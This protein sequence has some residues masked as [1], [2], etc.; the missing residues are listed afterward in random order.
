M[1]RNKF[2]TTFGEMMSE[3]GV[4]KIAPTP[5]PKPTAKRRSGGKAAPIP[6]D[7]RQEPEHRREM[8]QML[9]NIQ[10]L[11]RQRDALR[12]Q[13]AERD[14]MLDQLNT[15]I[16]EMKLKMRRVEET[17]K[18]DGERMTQLRRMVTSLKDQNQHL[19]QERDAL[20]RNLDAPPATPL[21]QDKTDDLGGLSPDEESDVR[22]AAFALASACREQGIERMVVVG[23][24]PRYRQH[25]KTLFSGAL[26]L[27]LVDGQERRTLKQ[28]KAD[29]AWADV[30]VI[31]GGTM[32]SHSLSALYR[33]EG[34]ITL[35]HRGLAGMLR[36]LAERL[37]G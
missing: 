20:R 26:A 2:E 5:P 23:G 4:K 34:V 15:R 12:K 22:N 7:S 31:W 11:R 24:S 10:Q 19:T 8:R 32:L 37:T 28:T 9:E 21:P 27:R 35:S 16:G 14:A 17:R 6:V 33:G 36:Q 29:E 1:P 13:L 3:L 30:V 18:R 25:L